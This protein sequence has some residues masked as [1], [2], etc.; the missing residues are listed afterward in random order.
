MKHCK[1]FLTL[2]LIIT[3]SLLLLAIPA[4]PA[5]AQYITL[6][7]TS[8]MRG[9]T[10]TITGIGFSSYLGQNVFIL[11]NYDYVAYALVTSLGSFTTSFSV[12]SY[13]TTGLAPVTVQHTT[14]D[15]DPTKQIAVA[16]FT[17]TAREIVIS[18]SSGYVGST[19]TVSGSDFTP[20]SSATIYFDATA[21]GT[22][23]TTATGTF[24]G[25][26]FTVPESYK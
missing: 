8:G 21:V 24:S 16:Y 4:T 9:T 10:V 26:T 7:P 20:S 12:P 18:P 6:S 15:Y 13:A 22:V 19:V 25:T 5:L 23:T 1:I 11:Y 17:V 14:F 2:A 3:L